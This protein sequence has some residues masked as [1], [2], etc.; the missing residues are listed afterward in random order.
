MIGEV[1]LCVM[2]RTIKAGKK[3][4]STALSLNLITHE[5]CLMDLFSTIAWEHT[6]KTMASIGF[7]V[8]RTVY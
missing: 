3:E 6:I 7:F 8:D 5:Y 1:S 2:F 4:L